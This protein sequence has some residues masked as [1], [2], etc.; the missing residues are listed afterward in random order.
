VWIPDEV[1][2]FLPATVVSVAAD[3]TV[4]VE[5][6]GI[7]NSVYTQGQASQLVTISPSTLD[8]IEDNLVN[9][10]ELEE[11]PILYQVGK[12][13]M[14]DL[15]Y[16]YV[17]VILVAV[18]PF[19]MLPIYST[20][21][22]AVKKFLD[23]ARNGPINQTPHVYSI[24]ATAYTHLTDSGESQAVLISGESGAGK[25]ETTKKVLAFL[26]AV[27]G[28]GDA[29]GSVPIED[30]IMQSN[31]ILEAFGNAKTSRNNNSSRFGKW[32]E[33]AFNQ[34]YKIQ[35]ARVVNY[36]LEKSR[37]CAQS[38]GERNYHV[39]YMLLEGA[40]RQQRAGLQLLPV[41]HYRYLSSSGCT[42]VERRDEVQE[43]QDMLTAMRVLGFEEEVQQEILCALSGVLRL[44]NLT[45]QEEEVKGEEVCRLSSDS[46]PHLQAA[47]AQL[48]VPEH[49]LTAAVTTR[50]V[51]GCSLPSL[52]HPCRI[53]HAASPMPHHR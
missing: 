49:I 27:A 21:G 37:I 51:R 50:K 39:F 2:A 1:Q 11:G 46:A 24:S 12:R 32:M 29:N 8:H 44:G 23:E 17:G 19:R 16:T 9:L 42:T 48:C 13:Y 3:G 7:G 18:N 31:P 52:P 53:T 28:S 6:R 41:G 35:G 25:T 45:F 30:Q 47:A 10:E 26:S 43:Y 36:L 33:I 5:G 20:D 40:S 22:D 15:I 38:E 14:D 4:K 34:S